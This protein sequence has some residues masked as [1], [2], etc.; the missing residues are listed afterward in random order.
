MPIKVMRTCDFC[1]GEKEKTDKWG[2]NNKCVW[3]GGK[4][5]R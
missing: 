4:G 5:E 2:I 1:K 3:G